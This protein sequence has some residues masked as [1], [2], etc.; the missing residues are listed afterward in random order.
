MECV[1]LSVGPLIAGAIAH[2][3]SWRVPFY[4]IVPIALC[5]IAAVGAFV[6]GLPQPKNANLKTVEKYKQ[7]D[8]VG[9]VLFV[10][11]TTCLVLAM[12]WG[13]TA[14][15]WNSA[16]II[17]L[18]VLAVLLAAAFACSQLKKGDGAMFPLHLLKQRSVSI[19][20]FT[21]FCTAA[22]LF[23]YCVYV[24]LSLKLHDHRQR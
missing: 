20:S 19:G 2:V 5:N 23:V 22:S 10:P 24:Y 4:I 17:T 13:G 14:Y 16:R 3:S 7:L 9:F 1:A 6:E 15:A 8:I 21:Q 12:Q 11:A 18:L